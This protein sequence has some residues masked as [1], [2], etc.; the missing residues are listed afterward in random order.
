M[1]VLMERTEAHKL[2]VVRQEAHHHPLNDSTHPMVPSS[3]PNK[4]GSSYNAQHIKKNNCILRKE[5][6]LSKTFRKTFG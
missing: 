5:R 2:R 1:K 4:V 3:T 6:D